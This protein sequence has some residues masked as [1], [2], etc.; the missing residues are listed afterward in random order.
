MQGGA[1]SIQKQTPTLENQMIEPLY[2]FELNTTSFVCFCCS[3]LPLLQLKRINIKMDCVIP[4]RYIKLFAKSIQCLAKVGDD[5]FLEATR[6]KVCSFLS[7]VME[8]KG[9]CSDYFLL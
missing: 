9:Q 3:K 5:L 2:F 6:E 4:N 7:I 1:F 8:S